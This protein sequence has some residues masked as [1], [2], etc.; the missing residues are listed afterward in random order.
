MYHF[1]TREQ[2]KEFF[3]S[4]VIKTIDAAEILGCGHQNIEDL[5]RRGKLDPIKRF[6][7]DKLFLRS[8]VIARKNTPPGKS[9]PKP[10][11][12]PQET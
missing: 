5:V 11:T 6:P 9:G 3:A 10:R 8:E 12:N 2:L 7:R 4:E 1:E